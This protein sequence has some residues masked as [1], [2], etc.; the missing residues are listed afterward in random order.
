VTRTRWIVSKLALI[1]IPLIG[2]AALVGILEVV[3]INHMGTQGNHWDWFDQQAPLTV[4]A[5]VFAL[6]LGVAA[7]ALIGRSI[8]AMAVTLIGVVATRPS[9]RQPVQALVLQRL[10]ATSPPRPSPVRSTRDRQR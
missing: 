3:L 9:W 4:A 6:A 7:G 5:T 2:A 1:F 10:Q 8:P